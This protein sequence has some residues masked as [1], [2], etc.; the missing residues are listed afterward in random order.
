MDYKKIKEQNKII[1]RIT[2]IIRVLSVH[3]LDYHTFIKYLIFFNFKL[4]LYHP[5]H[6]THSNMN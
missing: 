1:I 5:S 3:Y 2:I 4:I 6:K